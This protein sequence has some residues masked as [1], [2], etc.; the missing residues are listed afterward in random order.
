MS[1]RDIRQEHKDSE[2]DPMLRAQR[3]QLHEEWANQ[4]AIGAAAALAL[5]LIGDD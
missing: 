2:G 4:N 3:R 1:R 5:E